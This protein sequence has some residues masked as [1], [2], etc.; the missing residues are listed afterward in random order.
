MTAVAGAGPTEA[1]VTP[2]PNEVGIFGIG[3]ILGQV[4]SAATTP[5]FT[6][7]LGPT[8]FGLLDVAG[9]LATLLGT[10]LL[11]GMDQAVVRCYFDD[12]D[13]QRRRQIV[14]SGLLLLVL[15]GAGTSVVLGLLASRLAG[16]ILGAGHTGLLIVVVI[17]APIA[18]VAAYTAEVLRVE[19][20]ALPY[21]ASGVLR[22]VAGGVIAVLLVLALGGGAAG[23]YIGLAAG[24]LAAVT[25]NVWQIR[26]TLRWSPSSSGL[27][28]MLR[29]G[30]PLV[31]TGAFFW[32]LMVVDRLVLVRY[33]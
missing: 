33:V 23:V 4:L 1:D 14:S 20:R 31:P 30:L 9:V 32:S 26:S 10:V 25:Y 2:V 13:P 3:L 19:R 16:P 22:A 15:L 12:D 7:A 29:F 11:L 5:L 27:T 18:A 28:R 8:D 6:R 24:S 17:G 21:A